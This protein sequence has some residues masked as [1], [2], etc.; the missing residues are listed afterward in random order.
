MQKETA[1]NLKRGRFRLVYE[2]L[3]D[4]GYAYTVETFS[5][6]F[7]GVDSF[8]KYAYLLYVISREPCAD[9]HLL[10]CDFLIYT[11]T[12]C[13]DVYALVR[14]HILQ[15]LAIEPANPRLEEWGSYFSDCPS[16]PFSAAELQALLNGRS[17]E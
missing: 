6:D 17:S 4:E 9:L 7:R 15:A 16:A 3:R 10:A 11:D 8:R 1:A 13:D 2:A 5:R 14:W 12:F